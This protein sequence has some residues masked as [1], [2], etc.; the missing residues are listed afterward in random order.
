MVGSRG[1]P[2]DGYYPPVTAPRATI[3]AR[4]DAGAGPATRAR[5]DPWAYAGALWIIAASFWLQEPRLPVAGLVVALTIVL[6]VLTWQGDRRLAWKRRVTAVAMGTLFVLVAVRYHVEVA[7]LARDGERVAAERRERAGRA[8]A[9]AFT[10]TGAE[11][12]RAVRAAVAAPEDRDAA[13]AALAVHARA[14]ED[15]AVLV[16]RDG[17]PWAWAGKLVVAV[18]SLPAGA[19]VIVSPFY[20]VQYAVASEGDRFAVASALVHAERPADQ[21]SRALDEG[22]AESHGV[23]GFIYGGAASAAD[24]PGAVVLALGAD[25]LLAARAVVP[26]ADVLM[27]EARE[28]VFPAATLLLAL[29][30]FAVLATAWR[31]DAGLASRLGALAVAFGA[32]AIVPLNALSNLSPVFD[33]T[34]YFVES[35]GRLTANA[36]A[37][38]ITSA[39]LLLGVLSA[40][41]AGARPPSRTQALLGVLV[42]AGVGPFVLRE[43]SRG[44]QVPVIGVPT[45][46]WVAWQLTL[47]LAAVTVL[48]LGV[49][50]GQAA[51]GTRRGLRPW[52]APAI[53]A[54]AAVS[55]P[56]LL[57][58]PVRLPAMHPLLWVIAIAALAFTRRARSLVLPVA[59]VAACGAVTLTWYSSVRDRVELATRDVL[60]LD[61][62]D[63]DAATLLERFVGGLDP[64]TAARSRVDLLVNFAA[65]ELAASDHPLEIATW[66]PD[67]S[68]IA[69]LRVGRGSSTAGVNQYALEAARRGEM[70]LRAV[71]GEPGVHIVLALPHLDGTVTTAVMAPRTALVAP[72]AFGAILG[73]RAPPQPEP[74]YTL[75]LSD[76]G[77]VA[78][79]RSGTGRWARSGNE[80]H[81]DWTV[82][83]IGGTPR[84]VHATVDLRSF[85]ALFMRGVLMVLLDLAVLGAVWLLIVAADGVLRR[86]WRVRRRDLLQSY[87]ARLFLALFASFLVPS[88]LFGSWSLRRVQADDAA[89]RDL[90]VRE[91]LRGVAASTDTVELAAMAQ[92]F[93]TPLFLYADGLLG[94]T[95]DPLLD[96]LAP[97]G[98]L[99]PP[100]IVSALSEGDEP[101]AGGEEGVG[102]A[103]VRLGYRAVM[104]PSGVQYVLAAP[105]RLDERLLDRRRNDLAVFLLF[106]LA[107][108]GI[109]ALVVSEAAS[110]QLSR[111][112]RELQGS[113]LA[114]ARAEPPPALTE[115][116]PVEF[117]PVF[118]AFRVMT[119]DLADSRAALEAAERRLAATLRNVASGVIAVDDAGLVMFANPRAEAILGGPLAAGEPFAAG[120]GD[121]LGERIEA[122]RGGTAEDDTFEVERDGQRLQVRA[123]RLAR[124][125]RRAVIT[126]D[127]VTEVARA[128]RVLA[129]GEMAR[130]VAHEIKNPLTPIRLGMQHLQ[131]AHRDGRVDFDR[132][133]EENTA[134]VL[135]EIDR[136]DEIARAFSRYGSPPVAEEPA[137]PVDVAVIARDVLEL[138]RMGA[139]RILWESEIAPGPVIALARDRELREVL[140][141]LLENARLARARRVRL[142]VE[143]GT[144]G[145]AV[146]RVTD[147]G[148]GIPPHLLDRV[149]EP[150][151]STRTSGSGLGLAIS[152]R[153]IEGW[154]GAISADSSPG[155]GT[156][157]TIWLAPPSAS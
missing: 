29:T 118:N 7:A 41:R 45:G 39:L 134:R 153:M 89:A 147:D 154:G 62:A 110:R 114:L 142:R 36:G 123:A 64:A 140:L 91:T 31:R 148:D 57:E 100:I 65:S 72:D 53:A 21:L 28:R 122:F 46:L 130:Q 144:D 61:R 117:A 38:A 157:L 97:V 128:E 124:G 150:H 120:L 32:V 149:F 96:A 104:D 152:R 125:A 129:W 40:L 105:A 68:P 126:L 71:P 49:V 35:G 80:L 102:P 26:A 137:G 48:L 24:V 4:P 119:S 11:L 141:N 107:L 93:D 136:L 111:P 115:D 87:R 58:A 74:P 135:A 30:L 84:S 108:G 116:P 121:E 133:L 151:F 56:I 3:G 139:E 81:G 145:G 37:L 77:M 103:A 22:I 132:V 12:E 27:L 86:W 69:E 127:D 146:I 138:E 85:D 90:V 67:G 73:L 155:A 33:P 44:L 55:S 10:R 17:R 5:R 92:R 63:P 59:F 109:V 78:S 113:A 156:T 13:F 60:S 94:R 76:A 47:F 50:S 83:G 2:P 16:A 9:E 143:H 101:T 70:L 75:R 8:L 15:R 1:R 54:V 34:F 51:L 88:A 79:A 66:E 19:N 52:V 23:D 42:V 43:L 14:D 20:I 98:R 106:A 99:L 6:A 18:D 131:R 112:I 25:S 95:S 82:P